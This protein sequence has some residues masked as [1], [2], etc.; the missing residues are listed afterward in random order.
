MDIES[1]LTQAMESQLSSQI[2]TSMASSS[3]ESTYN[4]DTTRMAFDSQMRSNSAMY[5]VSAQNMTDAASMVTVAQTGVTTIKY[6]MNEMYNLATEMATLDGLTEE[7]YASY[8]SQLT[9]QLEYIM[10]VANETEF[11][12]MSLLNGTAGMNEDGTVVLS[13]GGNAMDQDFA[14]L[15]NTDLGDNVVVGTDGSMNLAAIQTQID[16]LAG[17]SSTDAKAYSEQLMTNL[18]TYIQRLEGIEAQ[19]S[20]DIQSLTSLAVM[21]EDSAAIMENTIVTDTDTTTEISSADLLMSLLASQ[22]SG[23][24]VSGTS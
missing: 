16:N 2:Y 20:Y 24:I 21:Y 3:R 9:S 14:N 6:Q 13:A 4:S 23:S 18:E 8:A 7:Q 11:N 22:S 19:Y 15:V 1:L 5:S 17:M 12:G 10:Q